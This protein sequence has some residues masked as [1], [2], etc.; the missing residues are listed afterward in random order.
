MRTKQKQQ[1]PTGILYREEYLGEKAESQWGQICSLTPERRMDSPLYQA[2]VN[3]AYNAMG[4]AILIFK[5][6]A[7]YEKL[8]IN[9][10]NS[11]NYFKWEPVIEKYRKVYNCV[12]RSAL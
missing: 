7:S 9:G 10:I 4:K 1:A 5:N 3:A 11:L 2:M 8:I 6:S 12:I